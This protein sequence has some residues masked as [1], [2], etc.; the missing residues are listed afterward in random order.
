MSGES[1]GDFCERKVDDY[2]ELSTK[3]IKGLEYVDD[4]LRLTMDHNALT[5]V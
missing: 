1:L 4:S 5:M 3:A 2:L